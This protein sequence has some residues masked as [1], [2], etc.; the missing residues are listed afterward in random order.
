MGQVHTGV[1]DAHN[2]IH[3]IV[4]LDGREAAPAHNLAVP[5]GR[6]PVLVPRRPSARH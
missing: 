1:S 6:T 2:P 3:D 5:E 4:R